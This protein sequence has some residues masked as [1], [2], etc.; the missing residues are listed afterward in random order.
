M[1]VSCQ[2]AVDWFTQVKCV[3]DS[4]WTQVKYLCNS[5]FDF[6]FFHCVCTECFNQYGNRLC[7]TDSISNLYFT[8][9]CK[10]GSNNIFCNISCSVSGRTVNFCWVFAGECAAAVTCITAVCIYDDFSACQAGVTLWATYYKTACWVD[11]E[12]CFFVQQFLWN[13]WFDYVVDDI[14]TDLFQGNIR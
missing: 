11:E 7:N 12:F 3:D 8:F 10:T 9:F 14:N 1:T 13:D 2:L 4:S 6:F 5:S